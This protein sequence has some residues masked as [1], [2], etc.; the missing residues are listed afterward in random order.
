MFAMV[1]NGAMF[2]FYKLWTLHDDD[3][4]FVCMLKSDSFNI[5]TKDALVELAKAEQ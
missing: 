5:A 1:S 2:K 3:D 4:G